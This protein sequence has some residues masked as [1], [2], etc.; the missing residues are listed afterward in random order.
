[1]S[2]F[3]HVHIYALGS[4]IVKTIDNF[5]GEYKY[6]SENNKNDLR[7]ILW[8]IYKHMILSDDVS[9]IQVQIK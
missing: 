3:I 7:S 8:R 9:T 6:Y 1:M 4:W 2:T 5:N